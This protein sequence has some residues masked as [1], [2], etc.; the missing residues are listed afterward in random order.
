MRW[1]RIIRDAIVG[2]QCKDGFSRGSWAPESRWGSQGGRVYST[3]L[4]ALC[5]E[6]YYRYNREADPG[7]NPVVTTIEIPN[8]TPELTERQDRK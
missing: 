2:L 5:L 7:P 6:V 8:A 3:A 1:N 4:A